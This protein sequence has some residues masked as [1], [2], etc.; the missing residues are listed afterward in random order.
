MNASA[1]PNPT[2]SANPPGFS[3]AG[4]AA[5]GGIPSASVVET[6][7][8]AAPVAAAAVSWCCCLANVGIGKRSEHRVHYYPL[9]QRKWRALISV[10]GCRDGVLGLATA[11]GHAGKHER[12][13]VAVHDQSSSQCKPY[14]RDVTD[15]PRLMDEAQPTFWNQSGC[16]MMHFVPRRAKEAVR[17]RGTRK[18]C[19][20]A[21]HTLN[22]GCHLRLSNP[23]AKGQLLRSTWQAD[24]IL[25]NTF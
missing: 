4:S 5:S 7:T 11:L 18:R 10:S 6:P 23:A 17:R 21:G 1:K 20:H 25:S 14:R 13:G 19:C 2:V 8:S 15:L 12:R 22:P 9:T 3:A 24:L 16:M